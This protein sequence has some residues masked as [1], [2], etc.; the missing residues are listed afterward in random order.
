[1]AKATS[2]IESSGRVR[3]CCAAR[4]SRHWFRYSIGPVFT[5]FAAYGTSGV[6][7]NFSGAGINL[8]RYNGFA[9]PGTADANYNHL[10]HTAM[11]NWNAGSSS[12]T[13]SWNSMTV[14]TTYLV[15]AWLNDGRGGQSGNSTFTG[16][17]VAV[18]LT[19]P[20]D[21]GENTVL[22]A[23]PSQNS[24]VRACRNFRINGTCPAPVTGSA[25]I[26]GLYTA[27]FG[28]VPV[29]K[30]LFVRASTMVGGFESLAREF[31]ARV[32]A[33]A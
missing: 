27:E 5:R 26:T 10:L 17:V 18:K 24:A 25:D 2:V 16:G 32:P 12:L 28:A 11:F 29:G 22:R 19:C 20:A 9:D 13:V 23:S 7:F 15:E 6:N 21:P 30:R 33:A 3:N 31:Q 4:S 1:M 14:G 8:D